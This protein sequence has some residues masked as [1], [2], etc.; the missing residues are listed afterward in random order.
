M[1]VN[2]QDAPVTRNSDIGLPISGLFLAVP[3]ALN[4]AFNC[5]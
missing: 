3:I 4:R 1:V 5:I 2:E